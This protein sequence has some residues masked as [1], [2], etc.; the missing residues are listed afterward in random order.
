VRAFVDTVDLQ[1]PDEPIETNA[2]TLAIY[3]LS[4]FR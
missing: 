1:T 3:W 4:T 2:P